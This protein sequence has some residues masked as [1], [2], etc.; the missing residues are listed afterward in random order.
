M[1]RTRRTLQAGGVGRLFVCIC[2]AHAVAS[3]V[4]FAQNHI[5]RCVGCLLIESNKSEREKYIFECL[6]I[7][8]FV[9]RS[10]NEFIEIIHN[11]VKVF[12]GIL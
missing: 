3:A 7:L 5:N 11:S 2:W 6:F 10:F 4:D 9:F 12:M 1:V 8:C